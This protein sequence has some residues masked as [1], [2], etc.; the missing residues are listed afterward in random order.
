[1]S[2]LRYVRIGLEA[3]TMEKLCRLLRG[4]SNK[5]REIFKRG[6]KEKEE[7]EEKEQ[8]QISEKFRSSFGQ[9]MG[10]KQ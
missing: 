4:L 7:G 6:R 5:G 10:L 9:N 3:P 2:V 8:K 1:M